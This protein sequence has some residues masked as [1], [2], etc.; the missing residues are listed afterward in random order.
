MLPIFFI[1][2]ES[3]ILGGVLALALGII[4]GA[5]PAWQAMQLKISEALRRGG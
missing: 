1:S 5:L 3:M 4:A 2:Q